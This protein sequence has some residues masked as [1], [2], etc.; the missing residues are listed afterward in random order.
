MI[1]ARSKVTDLAAIANVERAQGV[2]HVVNVCGVYRCHW[3]CGRIMV[4][5]AAT[6]VI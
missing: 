4:V 1:A 2:G 3:D 6:A 5:V